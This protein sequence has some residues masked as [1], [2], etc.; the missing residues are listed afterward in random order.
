VITYEHFVV[1]EVEK[2]ISACIFKGTGQYEEEKTT[3][4]WNRRVLSEM[5]IFS[6]LVIPGEKFKYQ[7]NIFRLAGNLITL[8]KPPKTL[9]ITEA[10]SGGSSWGGGNGAMPPTQRPDVHCT[11][12]SDFRL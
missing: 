1:Q 11:Y 12:A 2:K 8:I 4:I 10:C 7:E 3:R 5:A 6:V 9:Y